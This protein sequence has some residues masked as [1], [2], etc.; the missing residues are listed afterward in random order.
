[1][2]AWN[3]EGYTTQNGGVI[4]TNCT[5]KLSEDEEEKKGF[6]PIFANSEWDYYPTCDMCNRQLDYVNLTSEG[7]KYEKKQGRRRARRITVINKNKRNLRP[8]VQKKGRK[9]LI[10]KRS[11]RSRFD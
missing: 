8:H 11:Y 3:Y 6:H 4:C 1:M 10:V 2:K 9:N 5:G 7:R